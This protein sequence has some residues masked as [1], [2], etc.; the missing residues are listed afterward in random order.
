[1][2]PPRLVLCL[3][4]G[5]GIFLTAHGEHPMPDTVNQFIDLNCFDCHNEVDRKG[6][7]DLEHFSFEANDPVSMNQWILLYDRVKHNEMPPKKKLWPPKEEKD[8]FIN[9]LGDTLHGVSDKQQQELG[10]VRS[11]R[12]N[13]I[14]YEKS[15][16][17]LLGV[18]IPLR[19]LIPEDPTQ[20]GFS[21][22]AEAQQI[23]YHLLQKYLEAAD[24][25]L[26]EAFDRALKP[27]KPMYRFL[28]AAVLANNAR[29]GNNRGPWL[30][31]NTG[32]VFSSSQNYHGRM[33]ATQVSE[34][35]WY[36]IRLSARAID[37][38]EGHG[39]W[40]S[41]RSGIC[42]AKAPVMFWIGSFE[43]TLEAR[44]HEFTAWIE[45]NHM[46]EIRPADHTLNRPSARSIN[47]ETI[48]DPEVAKVALEFI[49]MERIY[50]G[51]DPKDLRRQLFGNLKVKDRQLVSYNP[52]RDLSKLMRTFAQKAFRRKLTSDELAPYLELALDVLEDGLPLAEVVRSGYRAILCS[53]RFLF[54]IEPAG[55][56]DGYSVASRLSYF[57][58]GT[59]PDKEL[60]N[61]ARQKKLTQP[62]VLTLQVNRMLDDPRAI[63]F[64]K[65]FSD[66]WLNLKDIDFT[67]PDQNLYPEFDEILKNAMLGETHAFLQEMIREDLSVTHVIDSDFTML[68]ERIARHYGIEGVSGTEFRKVPLKPEYRRGGI[69]THASVLKVTANGTTTSPV[70]RGVWMLERIMGETTRPPPDD[71]PAIE[72]D[73][74]G[75]KTIREQL[76]K[77]R[78]TQ[79]CAVCHVK[80]DPP[81]FALESYDVIGGWRDHYRAIKEKGSWQQGPELDPSFSM[82][83]GRTFQDIGEFKQLILNNPEKIARNLVEK[84]IIF[85]TGASIEFADRKDIDSILREISDESYGFRSL[86]HA[87][88][89]SPIFLNK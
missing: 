72:P 59:Y 30:Y 48:T 46:L 31:D 45:E 27:A 16:Q 29:E 65:H 55:K 86:I 53:P 18:D 73:I 25:A 35:G 85:A 34:S 54:F 52:K 76:D 10:R 17:D 22:V 81:G 4:L 80:I 71:V 37:P 26:D 47:L 50:Q 44:E 77:H 7:L 62:K 33:R 51:P 82:A 74:R 60:L 69:I 39:V 24:A 8:E 49:E 41:V 57:L 64:I 83:D 63:S 32:I 58:W 3:C 42:Y 66:Q 21:N 75:S 1:M 5:S 36:R 79:R 89:Q 70:I 14:E 11:R 78:N 2:F 61:L 56:L 13:R 9:S 87:V 6:G 68:N 38:P 40:T 67:T 12:L 15:V 28:E 19:K 23:S 84:C 20:D 43:A 88:V